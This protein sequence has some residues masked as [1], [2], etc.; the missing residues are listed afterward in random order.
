MAERRLLLKEMT[1]E[2]LWQ[3]LMAYDEGLIWI[4]MN[5]SKST[6]HYRMRKIF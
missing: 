1:A 4:I 2:E 5:C 6:M 3:D